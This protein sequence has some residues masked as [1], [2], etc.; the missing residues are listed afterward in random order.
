M[1]RWTNYGFVVVCNKKIAIKTKLNE[2]KEWKENLDK[3]KN[4]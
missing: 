1:H 3:I 2:E 4:S